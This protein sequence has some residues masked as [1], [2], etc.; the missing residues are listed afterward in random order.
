[1]RGTR[2]APVAAAMLIASFAAHTAV[3]DP[4][5]VSGP[6]WAGYAATAPSETP[7]SFT[8][9][10]GAWREPV[11]SCSAG[12]A[13]TASAIWVGLGGFTGSDPGLE[14]I[15]TNANCD[16][17]GRPT[18]FAWFEV[19]P[20][21]AYPI[22]A[23]VRPGDSLAATV[24]VDGFAVRLQLQNLTRRWTVTKNLSSPTPDTSSAEWIVEAPLACGAYACAPKRLANFG[25]VS[26]T[27]VAATTTANS[28]ALTDP[29]WSVTAIRLAPADPT[30]APGAVPAPVSA[31][32][33][34]FSVVW[35]P[36]G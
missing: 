24:S 5:Q 9:V 8:S 28:G 22:K 32:G 14:Q 27:N 16:A 25:S 30:A 10:H 33:E 31:D 26:M 36:D 23:K 13:G 3:A 11:V 6:N 15:G 35:A 34:A 2:M 12:G 29:S 7:L 21:I 17:H 18:Y 1:M 19:L 4:V 20:Y